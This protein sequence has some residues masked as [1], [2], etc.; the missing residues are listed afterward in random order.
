[1]LHPHAGQCDLFVH[2]PY[3]D[4]P[5]CQREQKTFSD[6]LTKELADMAT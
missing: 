1:M 6:K 4:L 2:Y 3:D 5:M